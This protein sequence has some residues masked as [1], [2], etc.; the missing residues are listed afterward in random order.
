M[1]CH[2]EVLK[3]QQNLREQCAGTRCHIVMISNPALYATGPQ[4]ESGLCC[5]TF[6]C[7][8]PQSFKSHDRILVHSLVL[9]P[10][11]SLGLCNYTRE[12]FS[13]HCLLLPYFISH[14]MTE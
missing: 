14:H 7:A 2:I 13:V 10:S 12:F 11:E 9:Q 1:L 5:L 4:L 6:L 8:F 3:I